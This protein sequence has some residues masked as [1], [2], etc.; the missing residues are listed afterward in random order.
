MIQIASSLLTCQA[1]APR[2]CAHISAPYRYWVS[3]AR[4]QQRWLLA[5]RGV[6]RGV[7][8]TTGTAAQRRQQRAQMRKHRAAFLLQARRERERVRHELALRTA[9]LGRA[10]HA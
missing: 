10:V 3:A 2:E 8:V 6:G 7:D 4:E 5:S 1:I 9:E